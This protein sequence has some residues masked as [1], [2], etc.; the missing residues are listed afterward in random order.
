MDPLEIFKKYG[1][2]YLKEYVIGGRLDYH[3]M[4]SGLY[5]SSGMHLA[6]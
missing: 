1:T 6:E 2:H 3:C 5:V 4:T